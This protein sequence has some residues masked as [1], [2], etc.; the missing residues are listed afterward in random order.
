MSGTL[1]SIYN[2]SVLALSTHARELLAL[3]EQVSSGSRINRA[4]DEPSAAYRV[5]NLNSQQRSIENYIDNLSQVS[6]VLEFSSTAIDDI[7]AALADAKKL[8]GDITGGTGGGVGINV[9]IEGL[10]DAIDRIVAAANMKHSGKYI[11]GGT[12]TSTQPFAVTRVDG[13]IT[14]VTYQGSMHSREVEIASGIDASSYYVG[15]ELFQSDSRSEPVFT[16]QTGAAAGTGTSSVTG[17]VWLTVTHDGS[18]YRIS[19]DGGLTEVVVPLGGGVN[20]MVTD[21][22][23]GKVL[24]VDT[25]G[26]NATSTEWVQVPGTYDVFNALITIRDRLASGTEL[27]SAEMEELRNNAFGAIDELS[28]LLVQK[29]VAIGSKIGFLDNIKYS[30]ESLKYGTEDEVTRIEQA[31]IAQLAIDLARR[32]V[33]YQMSLSVAGK[34]LSTSLLDYI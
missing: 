22:R 30:L 34:L 25:T 29:S 2:N 8:L 31:D 24:Y 16:G 9:T 15:S 11:F 19:I 13:R 10:N 33:L 23:T 12:D 6:D 27:S 32:E 21:S 28:G 14:N 20:Q 5:L 1:N 18:N 4:S 3:Q 17:D 26:I 7:K